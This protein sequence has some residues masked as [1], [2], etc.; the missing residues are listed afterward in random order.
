MT[1][2]SFKPLKLR[3]RDG[4][5]LTVL[6]SLL[7][8]ALLPVQDMTFLKSERRFVM[9]LNRFCWERAPEPFDSDEEEDEGED[10]AAFQ[11][12]GDSVYERVNCGLTFDNVSLARFRGFDMEERGQILELLTIQMD[13]KNLLLRFAEGAEIELVTKR[14]SGHLEDLGEP[15]PT[16]RRPY[17]P[18]DEDAGDGDGNDGG[19]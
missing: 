13:G 12:V 5:D 1:S 10:D 7:Q 2:G 15:W 4:D 17:H 11:D 14:V 3:V 16:T 8:D 9:V 6:S 19:A 18:D